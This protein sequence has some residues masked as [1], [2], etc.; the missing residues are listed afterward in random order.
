MKKKTLKAGS[1]ASP[2]KVR[3]Y[4]AAAPRTETQAESQVHFQKAILNA[5]FPIMIYAEDGEVIEISRVWTE[6]TGYTH[7]DIP[8]LKCWVEKAF[9]QKNG[10]ARSYVDRLYSLNMKVEEGDYFITT[11][12]GYTRIW[13]FSSSPLSTLPDGRRLVISIASDITKR[14]AAEKEVQESAWRLNM[15]IERAGNGITVSDPLGHFEIFNSK[16]QEVTGYTIDEANSSGDFS[17]VLYPDADERRKAI[18]GLKYVAG[19]EG[20][21]EAETVIRAKDGSRKTLLVSTSVIRYKDKDMFLSVYRDITERKNAEE[22]I[23]AAYKMTRSILDMAPIGIYLVSSDGG[24]EYVNSA[25][26]NMSGDSREQFENM[27]VLNI[28]SYKSF[29]ID[30]S[31]RAAL[32]GTPFFIGPVEFTSYYAKKTT[33]RNFTGLPVNEGGENKVLIFVENL[34]ELKKKEAILEKTHEDLKCLY[35]ELEKKNKELQKLDKLKSDF[36][37]TVSHELRTPLSITKEGISLVLDEIPGKIN[38]KQREVLFTSRNH[39]DRLARIIGNLLDIS[40]IEAG[41]VG[42]KKEPIDMALLIKQVATFFKIKVQEKGL[43]LKTLVPKEGVPTNADADKVTQVLTNLVSNAIK[44]TEKGSITIEAEESEYEV[45]C[46][47]IDT[48]IGISKE[49]MPKVFYKF[50]QFSRV[51]GAGEKGTGL[52]LSIAKGIIDAHNGKIWVESVPGKG[53]RFTFTL[54]KK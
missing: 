17:S 38:D 23:I 13:S 18:E 3:R 27:N 34:T 49:N 54:P 48:G 25:M 42:I 29:G 21:H 20:Y 16:M 32:K 46:S 44:F 35:K 11:K 47:V 37:S 6:L 53:S 28:P 12:D 19:L 24:I 33:I 52:G 43:E 8:T 15:V 40:K 30:K 39:I 45:K 7:K 14:K 9:G 22:A 1:Q 50:Q 41:Q 5:P 36:I 26:V 2:R 4:L 51:P 31:I 10:F